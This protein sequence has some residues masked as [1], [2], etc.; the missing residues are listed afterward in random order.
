MLKFLEGKE[1][2]LGQPFSELAAHFDPGK[3][4]Y[5]AKWQHDTMG[6][7]CEIPSTTGVS[8]LLDIQ[9]ALDQGQRS[10]K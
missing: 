6:T 7:M 3:N 5:N 10:Y 2:F 1:T 9:L 8:M 4:H